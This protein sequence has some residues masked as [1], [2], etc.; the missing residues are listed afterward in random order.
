MLKEFYFFQIKVRKQFLVIYF[1]F[2]MKYSTIKAFSYEE[3]I[4][5]EN[6]FENRMHEFKINYNWRGDVK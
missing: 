6:F 5:R 3:K 4:K 2:L 1:Y